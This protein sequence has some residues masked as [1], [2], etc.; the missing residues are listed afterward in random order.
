M[1]AQDVNDVVGVRLDDATV[2]APSD[3]PLHAPL[4]KKRSPSNAHLRTLCLSALVKL[5]EA[6][7]D[8][9][10]L[11]LGMEGAAVSNLT[12]CGGSC[13]RTTTTTHAQHCSLC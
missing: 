6:G 8:E 13:R 12:R 10:R 5:C 4:T 11:R 1:A 2:E 7:G 3:E 9:E